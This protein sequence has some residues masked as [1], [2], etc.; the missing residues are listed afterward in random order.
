MKLF[1]QRTNRR[2]HQVKE[3][4]IY[5]SEDGRRFETT[6]DCQEW[7]RL[8]VVVRRVRQRL[9][10]SRVEFLLNESEVSEE[11]IRGHLGYECTDDCLLIYE[12]DD[13]VIDELNGIFGDRLEKVST[14]SVK[15]YIEQL[16]RKH[17]I[18]LEL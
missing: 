7:E 9:W 14:K 18:V 6:E 15:E 3:L 13:E 4:T 2:R 8:L 10:A 11:W 17:S 5:V 16:R 12:G 1:L